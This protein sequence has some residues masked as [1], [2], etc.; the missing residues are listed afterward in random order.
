MQFR[1]NTLRLRAQKLPAQRREWSR[2]LRISF[3]EKVEQCVTAA[4]GIALL[5]QM[6]R[7]RQVQG[8]C[9]TPGNILTPAISSLG[10]PSLSQYSRQKKAARPGKNRSGRHNPEPTNRTNAALR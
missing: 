10:A 6:Y 7:L 1:R 9:H 5:N 3:K 4:L 2:T 8:S